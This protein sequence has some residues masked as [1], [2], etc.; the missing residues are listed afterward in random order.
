VVLHYDRDR[1]EPLIVPLDRVAGKTRR[2]DREPPRIES[3]EEG[4][5]PRQPVRHEVVTHVLGT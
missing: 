3:I 5:S 4:L 2:R 1:V